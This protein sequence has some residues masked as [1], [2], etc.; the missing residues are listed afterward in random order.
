WATED[1]IPIISEIELGYLCCGAPIVAITGTNGKS[2]VTTL[3][4]EILKK[5]GVDVVVC[6]NL[7]NPF[8]DEMP[9]IKSN[10]IVVLEVSSF[11]L[12]KVKEFKPYIS[13]LLNISQNHFDRHPDLN[14]YINAKAQIFRNQNSSDWTILNYDDELLREFKGKTKA[15]VLYFS[16]TKKIVGAYLDSNLLVISANGIEQILCDISEL[17]IKGGHNVENALA[18]LCVATTL[19]IAPQ[20]ITDAVKDFK[21][22]EHRYE[23]VTSIDSIDFINDSKSTTVLSTMRALEACDRP[24]ILIAGGK[25][26][27]SDFRKARSMLASK[28]KSMV[29]IGTSKGKIKEDLRSVV[30]ITEAN[31]MEEAVKIA[32]F[33]AVEGDAVLLSPMC[34]SFDMFKNFEERGKVFKEAVFKIKNGYL[35]NT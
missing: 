9:N 26:K 25:D 32:Y 30:S 31:S 20:H 1:G 29:L 10:S 3:I 4:G 13:V 33:N 27:G 34:A 23:Y 28:V 21:G 8:C 17:K 19:G 14:S 24:V 5:A 22:L 18:S 12:E 35:N 2:T 11:Q 15:N 6:G 7:G 16:R